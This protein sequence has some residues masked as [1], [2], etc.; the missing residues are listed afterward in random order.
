MV[1]TTAWNLA[2]WSFAV[3]CYPV[4]TT[5]YYNTNEADRDLFATD[6]TPEPP[7]PIPF[8]LTT[9]LLPPAT[10]SFPNRAK[11]AA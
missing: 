11:E 10:R 1:E 2:N 7:P 9:P 3:C 8:E 6:R 4:D 5:D